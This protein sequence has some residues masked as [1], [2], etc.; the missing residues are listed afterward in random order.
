MRSREFFVVVFSWCSGWVCISPTKSQ[1][2]G[3]FLVVFGW[4]S[5][6]LCVEPTSQAVFF[7]GFVGEELK[8]VLLKPSRPCLSSLPPASPQPLELVSLWR[9]L[10]RK[11]ASFTPNTVSGK[12]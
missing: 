2:R 9:G 11:L 12:P 3:L 8:W 7:M 10:V 4:F 5:G 1:F 6:W